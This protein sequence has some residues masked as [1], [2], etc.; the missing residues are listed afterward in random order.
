MEASR[1]FGAIVTYNSFHQVELKHRCD[2]AR[3]SFAK[4]GRI[5]VNHHASLIKRVM[6]LY[7]LVSPLFLWSCGSW[8]L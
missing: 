6:S 7:N 8:N 3:A 5:L 1:L 2:R 4:Y